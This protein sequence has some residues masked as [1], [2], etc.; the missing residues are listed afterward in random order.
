MPRVAFP[1]LLAL[2]MILFLLG[3][4]LILRH[5]LQWISLS[6]TVDQIVIALFGYG[7]AFAIG[8]ALWRAAQTRLWWWVTVLAASCIPILLF[9]FAQQIPAT[10]VLGLALLLFAST[11]PRLA[12]QLALW[13][14]RMPVKRGGG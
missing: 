4:L 1:V 2:T 13:R 9:P 8:M 7:G 5:M 12:S 10:S 6:P 3:I 11:G 14:V